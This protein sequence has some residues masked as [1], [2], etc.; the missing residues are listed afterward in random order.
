M[1]V[2][3]NTAIE[4]VGAHCMRPV[5]AATSIDQHSKYKPARLYVI[6]LME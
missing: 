4:F 3:L 2:W 5:D 1:G 6:P